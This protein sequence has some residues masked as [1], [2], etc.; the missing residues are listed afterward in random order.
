MTTTLSETQQPNLVFDENSGD[1]DFEQYLG[2]EW[3][4]DNNSKIVKEKWINVNTNKHIIIKRTTKYSKS[5]Y[6]RKQLRHFGKVKKDDNI[7]TLG[8]DVFMEWNPH[9]F[10]GK[11]SHIV[12][13]YVKDYLANVNKVFP[14]KLIINN[15][16]QL[17]NKP[18]ILPSGKTWWDIEPEEIKE[19]VKSKNENEKT[20]ND[21]ERINRVEKEK[22]TY[23]P[24][25]YYIDTTMIDFVNKFKKV[26]NKPGLLW[27]NSKFE[28]EQSSKENEP[29]VVFNT[30]GLNNND[31]DGKFV[32]AHRRRNFKSKVSNVD[33]SSET[34]IPI[35]LRKM[36]DGIKYSIK[37]Y[38]FN[39]LEG[40]EPKDILDW[41]RE[42]N[43]DG[44]IKVTIPKSRKTGKICSFLFLNFKNEN[45]KTL[46]FKILS[47]NKLKFNHSIISVEDTSTR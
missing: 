32:P 28:K 25:Q 36:I 12:D 3:D 13:N 9:L 30:L 8:E 42:Y 45:D 40:I 35:H 5:V 18:T 10:K 23:I 15:D 33:S 4:N 16:I 39:S 19:M 26:R 37:L 43:V 46:A 24:A 41:V 1:Y 14:E 31:N 11:N 2:L 34:F 6:D 29:S 44:Y 20:D 17:N 27:N 21:V 22:Y 7:T 47:K 38:N